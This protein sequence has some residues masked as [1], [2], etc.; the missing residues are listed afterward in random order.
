MNEPDSICAALA[1]VDAL[2]QSAWPMPCAAAAMRLAVQDQ[3]I[4]RAADIVDRGVAR[5]LDHAGL[6]ID[7]DLADMRAGGKARDR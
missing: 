5:E 3:R 2:L 1:V 4:D 7:L 6:G